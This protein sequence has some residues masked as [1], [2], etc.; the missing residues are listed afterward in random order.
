MGFEQRQPLIASLEE[1]RGSRV[2]CYVLSDRETFPLGIPGFATQMS[3]EPHLVVE[4]LLRG[5]GNPARLDVLLMTRGGATESVWPLVNLLRAH[6]EHLSVL[7]PFRAH[8]AGTL[9]CLGA[10]EVLMSDIAELSPIDPTT[11]NQFNPRDPTNPA[12]QYGISVEDVAAF[13]ELAKERG[14]IE[15]EP[16]RLEVFKLLAGNVHPLALG[17]VQRST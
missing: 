17:N 12:N 8:S 7:V 16:H 1:A 15:S 14:G 11:G 9:L 13:F 3:P 6:T 5:M 4:D 10:E 2:L